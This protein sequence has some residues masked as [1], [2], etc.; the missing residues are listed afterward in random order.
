MTP[1]KCILV[2]F[3]TFLLTNVHAENGLVSC[4]FDNE[5]LIVKLTWDNNEEEAVQLVDDGSGSCIYEGYFPSDLPSNI[6]VTGCQSDYVGVQ[7]HSEQFGSYFF[8]LVNGEI[9]Y[10]TFSEED[11]HDDYIE[12]DDFDNEFGVASQGNGRQKRQLDFSKYYDYQDEPI[13][14][15]DF[16]ENYPLDNAEVDGITLP[17]KLI[18]NINVYLD[19]YWSLQFGSDDFAIARRVLKHAQKLFK[20]QSLATE[21]DLRYGLGDKERIYR[22]DGPPLNANNKGHRLL[23]KYL[24]SPFTIG[25]D[26]E[27]VSHLHLLADNPFKNIPSAGKSKIQTA[28]ADKP[29]ALVRYLPNSDEQRTAMTVAHELG[30][31]LGMRHDFKSID[32]KRSKCSTKYQGGVV[33]NYGASRLSWSNCSNMD[34]REYYGKVFATKDKFCLRDPASSECRCNGVTDLLGNGF[35]EHGGT[36]YVDELSGCND[37]EEFFGKFLSTKACGS[38]RKDQFECESGTCI[39]IQQRC[40]GFQRNCPNG[41]DEKR[42]PFLGF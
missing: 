3:L 34:F 30:H 28:C 24:R 25:D 8:S 27:V 14:N 9:Q 18:L 2:T 38:C 42:C 6:L 13:A 4:K 41:E 33:M 16:E 7:I 36:C 32:G 12:N 29:R 5:T 26:N 19:K 35:C 21:I 23:A 11:Y 20:D 17:K 10:P 15:D 1:V 31:L 37:K 40:D 22:S 39:P